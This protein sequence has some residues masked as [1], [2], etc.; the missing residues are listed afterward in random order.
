LGILA[1]IHEALADHESTERVLRD[2]YALLTGPADPARAGAVV[3]TLSRLSNL[4]R[5]RGR[6]QQAEDDLQRALVIAAAFPQRTADQATA[7]RNALA[8]TFKDTGRYSEAAA[9]YHQVLTEWTA[10][11][12]P[13]SPQVTSVHHNLAGLAHAHCRQPR[14]RR[15]TGIRARTW[16]DVLCSVRTPIPGDRPQQT[17]RST[18]VGVGTKLAGPTPESPGQES[19]SSHNR[20]LCEL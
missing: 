9:L 20:G 4:A 17:Q 19:A 7:A 16:R 3:G 10:R 13:T 15:S 6:Y 11:F 12:G 14:R 8:I 2:L 1:R 18:D 5:L